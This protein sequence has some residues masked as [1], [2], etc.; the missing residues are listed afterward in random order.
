MR[1]LSNKID[2]KTSLENSLTLSWTE[3]QDA[4]PLSYR[5]STPKHI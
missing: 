3:V 5:N 4:N 2:E 1:I